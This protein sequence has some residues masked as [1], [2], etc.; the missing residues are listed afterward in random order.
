MVGSS[1]AVYRGNDTNENIATKDDEI[2]F[3]YS[4][5]QT[6]TYR[7]YGFLATLTSL[8]RRLYI[9]YD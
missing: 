3:I 9:C 8:F 4:Q 2:S 7:R 5:K 6:K 1:I